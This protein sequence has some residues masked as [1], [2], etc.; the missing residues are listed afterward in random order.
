M[1]TIVEVLNQTKVIHITS[2]T[3]K[4]EQ[5]VA[6]ELKNIIGGHVEIKHT[7]GLS[8]PAGTVRLGVV[9]ESSKWKAI[10]PSLEGRK[11]WMMARVRSGGGI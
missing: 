2:S 7:S 9:P 1:P 10:H 3:T 4:V 5:T 11:D 6:H 8:A